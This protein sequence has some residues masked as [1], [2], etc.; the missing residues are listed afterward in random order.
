MIDWSKYKS[1]PL[2]FQV[3][4]LKIPVTR[5]EMNEKGA[6]EWNNIYNYVMENKENFFEIKRTH[7]GGI[8][9]RDLWFPAYDIIITKN[10]L[11]LTLLDGQ[12]CFRFLFRTGYKNEKGIGCSGREAFVKF[13]KICK[14]HNID[15]EKYAITNGKE[16]KETIENV[17]IGLKDGLKDAI[18]ENVQHID[19]NSAYMSGIM[20]AYPELQ[21]VVKEIYDKRKEDPVCK[22]ILNAS[23]GFFQSQWCNIDGNKYALAHLSKAGIAY[24]NRYV[25]DLAFRIEQQGGM[26]LAYNTDGLF[27]VSDKEYHDDREGKDLCQWK[28]D[29]KNIKI[30]FKSDGVYEFIEDGVYHPVVRG[31]T[32]LDRVKPRS[33]WK[34]G[35]IYYEEASNLI[36]FKFVEGKGIIAEG[37]RT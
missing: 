30:R 25:E 5:F 2:S 22:G 24:C 19:L 4:Y 18:Y 36:T 3:N 34:W 32:R 29:H 23:Q 12:G 10:S 35:E 7:S 28:T 33:E 15:L 1:I 8:S 26:V 37:E 17:H 27:Y 11:E 31:L 14:E 21:P 13:R 20:T 16:V 6:E 9:K